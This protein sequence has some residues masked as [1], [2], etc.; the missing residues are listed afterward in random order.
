M[1]VVN[2][3]KILIAH[4]PSAKAK[5]GQSPA[6][7]FRSVGLFL[8]PSGVGDTALWGPQRHAGVLRRP[9][10]PGR[11]RGCGAGFPGL[12]AIGRRRRGPGS[13]APAPALGAES[14]PRLP[15]TSGSLPPGS[16]ALRFLGS[17]RLLYFLTSSVN[18][19][20]FNFKFHPPFASFH[21]DHEYLLLRDEF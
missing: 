5:S 13:R 9:A 15:S 1:Q 14:A 12:H 8:I 7:P 17:C 21:Q 20:F 10:R 2:T 3:R 4:P 18:Y 16:P 19:Y 11:A 6:V